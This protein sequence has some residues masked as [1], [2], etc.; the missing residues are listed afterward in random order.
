MSFGLSFI[1]LFSFP[2][3]VLA[4]ELTDIEDYVY[5][6]SIGFLKNNEVVDGYSDQTYRPDDFINRAE[7]LKVTL[8][9]AYDTIPEVDSVEDCG[10]WDVEK[11]A[12]YVKY[13][14]FAEQESIVGGYPDGSFKPDQTVNF[15]EASKMAELTYDYTIAV[16]DPSRPWYENDVEFVSEKY[17]S[18]PDVDS[19][20][21]PLTRGQAAELLARFFYYQ[22][23]SLSD[24]LKMM[25]L[26]LLIYDDATGQLQTLNWENADVSWYDAV[27]NWITVA[28]GDDEKHIIDEGNVQG[29]YERSA[30]NADA[31]V[32]EVK[33]G[34]EGDQLVYQ[35]D[36]AGVSL[37]GL[38]EDDEGTLSMESKIYSPISALEGVA[39]AS[40]EDG[41]SYYQDIIAND[42]IS[43]FSW[44]SSEDDFS[45]NVD[46]IDNELTLGMDLSDDQYVENLSIET[47]EFGLNFAHTDVADEA[48]A[49]QKIMSESLRYEPSND[50]HFNYQIGDD[51]L[52]ENLTFQP[53]D[54]VGIT[55]AFNDA[56]YSEELFIA[57]GGM[58][59]NLTMWQ[60]SFSE[61]QRFEADDFSESFSVND[62]GTFDLI[63]STAQDQNEYISLA[64]DDG[65]LTTLAG[66]ILENGN[67]F[68][69]SYTN[70]EEGASFSGVLVPE[71]GDMTNIFINTTLQSDME[72]EGDAIRIGDGEVHVNGALWTLDWS[73]NGIN[74]NMLRDEEGSQV[75]G[76][77]D[78]DADGL[79][80]GQMHF[81]F[82]EDEDQLGEADAQEEE[83]HW[84][85]GLD[86]SYGGLIWGAQQKGE[87]KGYGLDKDW[88]LYADPLNAY[89]HQQMDLQRKGLK[90]Q[91]EGTV[92]MWPESDYNLWQRFQL[93]GTFGKT[94]VDKNNELIVENGTYKDHQ[95]V[96]IDHPNVKG[97]TTIDFGSDSPVDFE[98]NIEVDLPGDFV[99]GTTVSW[100]N[101][102]TTV[103]QW[104]KGYI[105]RIG[106]C[107]VF[108]QGTVTT[109]DD[110]NWRPRGG[111]GLSGSC[112]D[113]PG[114]N[115]DV[116]VGLDGD[117]DVVGGVRI[118]W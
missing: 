96:E 97:T 44:F 86:L 33:M 103:G 65:V 45:E 48:Y 21:A 91:F 12:W 61:T 112:V 64:F 28:L 89:I 7:F 23:G 94:K 43:Q 53:N 84:G 83:W 34:S 90:K 100:I 87:I 25:Q 39:T 81:G 27:V 78:F 98:Q 4:Q 88:E 18:P 68:E 110:Y 24:Y 113:G 10:F 57:E 40:V 104:I 19:L 77:M 62:N 8:E 32:G 118:P 73:D 70:G 93:G 117:Y 59:M 102:Q 13:I 111:I 107:D 82:G 109:T 50:L 85:K 95:E 67:D 60:D 9:S 38:R 26:D 16:E 92:T 99:T 71:T 66:N 22:L 37:K 35:F 47:D 6:D 72:L 79:S 69:L 11:G 101:G 76:D 80:E 74:F 63:L 31:L 54:E 42:D 49:D 14:C 29:W 36:E 41:A 58:N 105:G 114:W 30:S 3:L 115:V 55:M 75:E 108:G 106:G 56:D 52:S 116:N 15:V 51:F 46:V 17:L 1:L 20:D 2:L 5:Q